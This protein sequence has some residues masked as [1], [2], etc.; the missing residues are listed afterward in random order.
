[1]VMVRKSNER[2]RMCMDYTNLNKAYPKDPYPLP[3]I[4]QLVDD[5]SGHGSTYQRL[6]DRMFKD[7]I[8]LDLEVYIDDMVAKSAKGEQHYK[9]YTL[10]RRGIEANSDKCEFIINMRSLRS[11]KEV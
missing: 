8:G 11:V 6:I 1:M 9:G 2:W 7:R 3:S 5:A 4:D 10:I